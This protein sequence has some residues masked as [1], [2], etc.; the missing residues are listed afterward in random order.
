MDRDT[1][2][3]ERKRNLTE[4][5]RSTAR[6]SVTVKMTENLAKTWTETLKRWTANEIGRNVSRQRPETSVTVKTAENWVKTW[7]VT[8]KRWTSNEV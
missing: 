2:T 6:T 5:V 4:R 1:K 8:L 7:T 3:V